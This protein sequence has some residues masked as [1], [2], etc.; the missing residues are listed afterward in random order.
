VPAADQDTVSLRYNHSCS[1]RDQQGMCEPVDGLVLVLWIARRQQLLCFSHCDFT[2]YRHRFRH[3]FSAHARSFVRR[4]RPWWMQQRRNRRCAAP[5]A[6]GAVMKRR[7][8]RNSELRGC[9]Q[10]S[11]FSLAY[12]AFLLAGGKAQRVLEMQVLACCKAA[13]PL[14]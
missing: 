2:L 8:L 13:V 12:R 9:F 6:P 14:P 3:L 4:S 1:F 5:I 11:A 10:Q 7:S